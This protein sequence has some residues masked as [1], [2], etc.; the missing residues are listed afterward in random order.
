MSGPQQ[1]PTRLPACTTRLPACTPHTACM[2]AQGAAPSA[3]MSGIAAAMRTIMQLKTRAMAAVRSIKAHCPTNMQEIVWTGGAVAAVLLA[4]K[5]LH[6]RQA[7]KRTSRWERD[8]AACNRE[9][10]PHRGRTTLLHHDAGHPFRFGG[11]GAGAPLAANASPPPVDP[12]PYPIFASHPEVYED[13][14]TFRDACTARG[15]ARLDHYVLP[16][17]ASLLRVHDETAALVSTDGHAAA[18]AAGALSSR[19]LTAAAQSGRIVEAALHDACVMSDIPTALTRSFDGITLIMTPAEPTLREPLLRVL[20]T[21]H[22]MRTNLE[23]LRA[24]CM[25]HAPLDHHKLRRRKRHR[26]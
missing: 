10:A 8:V 6:T 7:A 21:V 11:R 9:R 24:A 1:I 4:S 16:V 13:I 17:V 23:T 19:V 22:D 26:T 3:G 15:A 5:V 18:A 12:S 25:G 2:A 20:S 14:A